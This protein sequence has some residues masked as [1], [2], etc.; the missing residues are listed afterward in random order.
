MWGSIRLLSVRLSFCMK[1]LHFFYLEKK[2]SSV[3]SEL[4]RKHRSHKNAG[5]LAKNAGRLYI[6][7]MAALPA[8]P[9]HRNNSDLDDSNTIRRHHTGGHAA[10]AAAHAPAAIAQLHW[11]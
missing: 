11:Q 10:A 5:R 1:I 6:S 7:L 8:M 2:W 3:V 4:L 9:Q